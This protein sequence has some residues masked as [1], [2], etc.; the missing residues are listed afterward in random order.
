MDPIPPVQ[1]MRSKSQPSPLSSFGPP[2]M[3][4]KLPRAWMMMNVMRKMADRMVPLRLLSSENFKLP[5]KKMVRRSWP[6]IH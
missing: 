6:E 5:V 1:W 3:S 4:T 2:S